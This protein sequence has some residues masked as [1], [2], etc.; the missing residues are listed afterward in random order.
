MWISSHS[1]SE[2]EPPTTI[3]AER[4]M[5]IP[6]N[7]LSFNWDSTNMIAE[8]K[9][10]RDQVELLLDGGPYTGMEEKQKVITLL[11]WMTDKGQKI[12]KEQLIFP[13]KEPNKKDK[14]K[15][16]DVLEVFEAYFTPLQSMIHSWYNLGALHSHHCKD[17]ADF[18]SQLR[19][20]SNDCAFTNA[21]CCCCEIPFP[22]SQ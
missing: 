10:F 18:M 19:S 12:Y 7:Q 3:M 2:S 16:N 17:Q 21:D 14:E 4:Y 8:W 5:N 11:N 13:T 20:L 15:L 9:C 1:V 22:N 6:L